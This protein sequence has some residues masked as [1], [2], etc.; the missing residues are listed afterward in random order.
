MKNRFALKYITYLLIAGF[1]GACKSDSTENMSDKGTNDNTIM[2]QEADNSIMPH[3]ELNRM[4]KMV[5]LL[6]TSGSMSGLIEQAKSQ[7]WKIVNQLAMARKDGEFVNLQIA[8]YEYGNSSLSS[9]TGYVRQILGMTND[10]D[11]IS[12]ELFALNTNGGSEYCGKVIAQS[13]EDL[14]WIAETE[15]LQVMFIAGN[16]PFTQGTVP[17][18]TACEN[19]AS[20]DVIVN[21][22]FCGEIEQGVRSKWKDG[23]DLTGGFY[24]SIEM[25][26]STFY[27]ESPFDEKIRQLNSQLN[28]TYLAYGS[29]KSYYLN[30]QL[31][32]DKNSSQYGSG[33]E[34]E[35]TVTKSSHLY[36]NEKWDLVDAMGEK[37]FD[38]TTIKDDNLPEEM[39]G[40]TP[41]E[42]E[43]YINQ[44]ESERTIIQEEIKKLNIKRLAYIEQ[45]KSDQD[46]KS[47]ALDQAMLTA[48]IEQAEAKQF[49]FE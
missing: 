3:S 25:N 47:N 24:S 19:A 30:N 15:G 17:Y 46:P 14:D 5:L 40:M 9:E 44:K 6:D 21:T 35:R 45:Q 26:R 13:L 22:I 1:L 39:I 41:L 23:A 34:V 43:E 20:T 10:L 4:I 2:P 48:I 33:N 38:I 18:Q 12:K 11:E 37:G 36:K 31:V 7:L 8:L 16:E 28:Q 49:V 42:K 29:Q 32:Q 27:I